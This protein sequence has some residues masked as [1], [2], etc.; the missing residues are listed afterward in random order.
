MI[1]AFV[2]SRLDVPDLK[3]VG[4]FVK[5]C[6]LNRYKRNKSRKIKK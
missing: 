5:K 1:K 4:I 2:E 6:K 3:I